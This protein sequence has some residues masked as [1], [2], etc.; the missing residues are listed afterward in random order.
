MAVKEVRHISANDTAKLIRQ[1][2]KVN[3]PDVKFSVRTDHYAGGASI[4]IGWI[5]GP[6]EK[7]VEK[8]TGRFAG[9][10]FD[11]TID[12]QSYHDSTYK[13]ERVSFGADYVQC[14]RKFSQQGMATLKAR[15]DKKYRI[16]WQRNVNVTLDNGKEVNGWQLFC[17]AAEAA[18]LP[19]VGKDATVVY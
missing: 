8:V 19:V 9:A 14:H 3:F 13:G 16:A 10:S 1:E 12:L 17:E 4:D 7:K 6:T 15:I 2:L 11:G 18:D 5:D